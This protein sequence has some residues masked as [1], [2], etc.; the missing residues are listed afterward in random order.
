MS[1]VYTS[2]VVIIPPDFSA[3][4]EIIPDVEHFIKW[5]FK[6][7]FNS[8]IDLHSISTADEDKIFEDFSKWKTKKLIV[9]PKLTH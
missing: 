4:R 5:I 3:I 1:K 8:P 7:V 2:A 6:T 9:N